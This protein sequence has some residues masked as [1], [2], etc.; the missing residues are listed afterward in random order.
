MVRFSKYSGLGNDFILIEGNPLPIEQIV[1]LCDRHDGIGA[2][3]IIFYQDCTIQ[4]YNSDGSNPSL[5]GNGL[6]CIFLHLFNEGKIST[7]ASIQ[8]GDQFY[9]GKVEQDRI[10]VELGK[11]QTIFQKK[12]LEIEGKTYLVDLIDTGVPHFVVEDSTFPFE[13]VARILRFHP[14]APHGANVNFLQGNQVRTYERGVEAETCAC[15]TGI[16][17]SAYSKHLN[18]ESPFP[19]CLTTIKGK[20]LTVDLKNGTLWIEGPATFIFQGEINL[21][22]ISKIR[23]SHLVQR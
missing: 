19:I 1:H 8:V 13:Q 6:R 10:A 16:A 9:Q 17:A 23:P 5:C 12:E 11:P 22:I 14:A 2:D 4:F 3:G 18:H 15:G 21:D 7:E 20:H